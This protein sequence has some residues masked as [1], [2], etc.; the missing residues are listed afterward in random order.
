VCGAVELF[1]IFTVPPQVTLRDAGENAYSAPL[2]TIA[3]DVDDVLFGHAVAAV[4]L[5]FGL[6]FATVG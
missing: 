5:G 1:V 6:V 3:S 2:F 4:E